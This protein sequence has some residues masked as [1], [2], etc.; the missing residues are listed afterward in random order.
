LKLGLDLTE[1]QIA[2][3][4]SEDEES[5]TERA[6]NKQ[7][8]SALQASLSDLKRL[9]IIRENTKNSQ[10]HRHPG[11]FLRIATT[12]NQYTLYYRLYTVRE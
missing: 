10:Q 3:L 8:L 7:L 5:I 12:N 4:A 2:T 6:R 11:S 1:D 9:E